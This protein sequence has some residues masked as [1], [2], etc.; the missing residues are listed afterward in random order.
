LIR[1]LL[2]LSGELLRHGW[3]W[4]FWRGF[5]YRR[6][7][8]RIC[9]GYSGRHHWAFFEHVLRTRRVRRVLIMGVYFGRDIAYLGTLFRLLG[10]RDYQIVG[11][12]RFEDAACEDWPVELQ[13]LGWEAAG[14]G[15][16]PTREQALAN[17]RRLG[18]DCH[19]E[20]VAGRAEEY[21]SPEPF[22]F[23]YIDTS[24]DYDVTF[25]SIQHGLKLATPHGL[26][27]GDDYEDQPT[28]GVIPAVT[29]SFA[30]HQV[31]P[32]RI[33]MAERRAAK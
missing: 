20:L 23:V 31:Y 11:V 14:F 2:R 10:I 17:L 4:R 29:D 16:P 12:D 24:H 27:A 19:V 3:S 7:I 18:L 26:L 25:K 22:D 30:S 32:H 1:R 5:W 28:W 21:S 6:R 13:G 33:W 9:R 8:H 15:P